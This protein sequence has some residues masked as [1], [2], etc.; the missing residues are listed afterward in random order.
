MS[1]DIQNHRNNAGVTVIVPSYNHKK[2][3]LECLDSIK[4]QTLQDFQW[5]VVDDGSS[6]GSQELLKDMQLHYGYELIL[7]KIKV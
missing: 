1:S 3:L 2:Y 5:I 4:N 6:D 7:Q